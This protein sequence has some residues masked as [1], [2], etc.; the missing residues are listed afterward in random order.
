MCVYH[1]GQTAKGHFWMD[2][3]SGGSSSLQHSSP[4]LVKASLVL[5]L[6][7]SLE[8]ELAWGWCGLSPPL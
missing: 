6:S 7:E 4:Y 1:R 5:R 8:S 2:F 3:L